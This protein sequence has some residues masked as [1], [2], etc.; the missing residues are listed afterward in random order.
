M[1]PYYFIAI[2]FVVYVV[3]SSLIK[4]SKDAEKPLKSLENLPYRFKYL[5]TP[6]E[7]KFYNELKKFTD[8]N[9]LLICPKVGLQDLFEVTDK[10]NYQTFLNKVNRKHIDFLVCDA[11]LKPKYAI[12]LDDKSHE[13]EKNKVSHDFKDAIFGLAKI[14]L[15]RVK[16]MQQ[17]TKEYV[18]SAIVGI[19]GSIINKA[20]IVS[21]KLD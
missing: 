9:G 4:K 15:I 8:E 20:T 14:P 21:E 11:T 2:V 5:L 1:E 3:Y 16:A 18:E 17:Y 6:N 7:Y 10:N 13:K 19:A 12:E